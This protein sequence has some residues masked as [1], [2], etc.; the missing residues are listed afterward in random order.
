MGGVSI[1]ASSRE[2]ATSCI[3]LPHVILGFQST[4]PRGRTRPES[5]RI[6][7]VS[8]SFNP[9][10]LAGGRDIL[11]DTRRH[12]M[13]VS[14]HASSREDATRKIRQ[15]FI[16]VEFQSTRPRG[17]TRLW[18]IIIKLSGCLFQSTRPRGRT[19]PDRGIFSMGL[20]CFNPR[21]LAGGRDPAV[22][23]DFCVFQFQST[24]PRGRTRLSHRRFS[25]PT[26]CFNPRVLAGG[27][28]LLTKMRKRRPI[29]SIHASSR[30]DATSSAKVA[31][32]IAQ[33]QSTRPRGRTRRFGY[34]SVFAFSVSI[35]ASS[36][37]DATIIL[38]L[39][40]NLSCFNPRVLAGGRDAHQDEPALAS[41]FQSTRPRGRTRPNL[42][43]TFLQ[44]FRFQSTRPRGRTRPKH[45]KFEG[46]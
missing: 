13:T 19:R 27:R 42:Y 11:S 26:P 30:E 32:E 39:R 38:N 28:D 20:I 33:F 21:V 9:R 37:E 43:R 7:E 4:R 25:P 40:R 44:S 31:S 1:H 45:P 6:E 29:V 8:G 36:R 12:L 10:V 3:D 35:H 17:R 18:G 14:I 5:L 22:S 24:R 34:P 41:K 23:P 46:P 16:E 2:D 15:Y